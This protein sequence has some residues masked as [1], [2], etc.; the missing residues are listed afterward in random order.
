[1]ISRV[2]LLGTIIG[3]SG[4]TFIPSAAVLNTPLTTQQLMVKAKKKAISDLCL[5][6]KKSK[7][8]KEIC[9]KWASND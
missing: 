5:K 7:S 2:L 8:V 3:W 9:D 4:S 1:M 6:K